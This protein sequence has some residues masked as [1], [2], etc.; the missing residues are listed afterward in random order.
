MESEW[1]MKA[2]P[3]E[4]EVK[5]HSKGRGL[6][7]RRALQAQQGENSQHPQSTKAPELIGI[8][9]QVLRRLVLHVLCTFYLIHNIYMCNYM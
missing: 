9:G 2:K 1:K 7:Q 5:K 6:R 8:D 3:S 4:I